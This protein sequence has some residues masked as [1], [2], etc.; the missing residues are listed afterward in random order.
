[1]PA[2]IA[3]GALAALLIW[4]LVGRGPAAPAA[5]PEAAAPDASGPAPSSPGPPHPS[6]ATPTPAAPPPAR[7]IAPGVAPAASAASAPGDGEVTVG[8]AELCTSLSA[9][10][11][12]E[13]ARS[14]VAPGRLTFYTRLIATRDT[15]VVHR[16]Y[17]G[18]ELRQAV[19]LGVAARRGGY[20]T[21]S[22]GT[23]AASA[24]EWRVELRT[25]DGRLLHTERFT[26]R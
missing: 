10:Y 4:L 9:A 16:W 8:D 19:R 1:V 7:A 25:R 15:S 13:P 23:V 24:G 11:R 26:V 5:E 3:L 21:F 12:C 6:P 2:L 17:R 18:D 14:P 20:R 22:R